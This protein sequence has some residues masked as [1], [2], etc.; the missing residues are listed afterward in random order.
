M[1]TRTSSAGDAAGKRIGTVAV[2]RSSYTAPETGVSRSEAASIVANGASAAMTATSS[3][4]QV[5]FL[6]AWTWLASPDT[7]FVLQS[8]RTVL[9]LSCNDFLAACMEVPSVRS[10][11]LLPPRTVI[12]AAPMR[13]SCTDAAA[14]I[15]SGNSSSSSSAYASDWWLLPLTSSGLPCAPSPDVLPLWGRESVLSGVFV[16]RP[17]PRLPQ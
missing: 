16:P 6:R 2:D 11:R 12:A 4:S 17:P 5:C 14:T 8:D 9:E 13:R 3:H 7:V 10:R 15:T 1:C